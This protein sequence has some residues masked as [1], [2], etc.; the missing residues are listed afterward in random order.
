MIMTSGGVLLFRPE[1]MWWRWL[2]G[3]WMAGPPTTLIVG[4]VGVMR[5][6]NKTLT[7]VVV[8]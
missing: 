8:E 1:P 2:S 3:E 7:G 5:V 4:W 6:S